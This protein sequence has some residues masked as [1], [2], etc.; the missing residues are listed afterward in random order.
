MVGFWSDDLRELS[1]CICR[2]LRHPLDRD[3]SGIPFTE[4]QR[5][6]LLLRPASGLLRAAAERSGSACVSDAA[7]KVGGVCRD[8]ALLAATALRAH[9]VPARLRAGF[10]D[11][12]IPRFFES[13]WLC[14][15]H[16]GSRWRLL[17]V[18][19][20]S[21]AAEGASF[22]FDPTDVPRA[23]FMSAAEAWRTTARA[24][25]R[26]ADRFGVSSRRGLQGRWFIAGNLLR[27][28]A[29]VMKVELKPWDVWGG[30][31]RA[32]SLT[33]AELDGIPALRAAAERL[34]ALAAC[35]RP[36]PPRG[37]ES[38]IGPER[39]TSYPLGE[40]LVVEIA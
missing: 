30:I 22:D 37:Y 28:E 25:P 34:D 11:Y 20:A 36:D 12:L 13:H 31:V 16:D 33:P 7:R 1:R 3:P 17:D 29:A 18:Q 6:D 21:W 26:D 24:S 40:P 39:V 15:W 38:W 8:F 32:R 4:A 10:A 27:D 9:K 35:D 2:L 19:V 14:E 5:Q 23:R